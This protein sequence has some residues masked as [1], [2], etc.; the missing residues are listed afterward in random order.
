MYTCETLK[1]NLVVVRNQSAAIVERNG[2][3]INTGESGGGETAM[4]GVARRRGG[5]KRCE[6]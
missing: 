2:H 1:E 6:T 5:R 3:N 4:G